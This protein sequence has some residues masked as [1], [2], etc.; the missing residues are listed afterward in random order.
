MNNTVWITWEDHRRSRVLASQ[1]KAD[2]CPFSLKAGRWARYPTLAL[3]TLVF[4]F[5][6]KPKLV[7]CQNPSIVLTAVACFFKPIM[8]YALIVD[9]HSN[10][11]LESVNSKN[12]KWKIFHFLSRWTVKKADLTIVTNSYL[13]ELCEKW[14]GHAT[15]LQDKI[16]NIPEPPVNRSF[17]F[18]RNDA[19]KHVMCITTFDPD[20]PVHEM[21]E[22]S[23]KFRD[24]AFYMTGNFRKVFKESEKD[25]RFEENTIF[26]GFIDDESYAWLLHKADVIVV[27]TTKEYLL[28]CGAYEAIA[29]GK[30]VL[31]SNTDTLKSYFGQDIVY[32]DPND[33]TSIAAGIEELLENQN[34][35]AALISNKKKELNKKWEERFKI[36]EDSIEYYSRNEY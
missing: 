23:R 17:D 31:L 34:Q 7:F 19:K 16:P 35:H 32:A 27:L 21:V 33:S 8:G 9:R 25:S 20:E 30:P 18:F 12:I 26:T 6:R 36:T 5:R 28:N 10:F 2:Y 1:F 11:K 24:T 15:V 14:Q 29:V 22:A 3:M 13:R 4:L